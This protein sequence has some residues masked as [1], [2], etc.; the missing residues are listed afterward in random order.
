MK[1]YLKWHPINSIIFFIIVLFYTMYS[2]NLVITGISFLSSLICFLLIFRGEKRIKSLLFY[3]LIGI[4]IIVSNPLISQN[5]ET[6]LFNIG[7]VSISYEAIVFGIYSAMMLIS[8]LIWFNCYNKMITA[9]K[10]LYL[11]GKILPSTSITLTMGMRFIPEF[12]KRGKRIRQAQKNLGV[13]SSGLRGAVKNG[14][15]QISMLTSAALENSMEVSNSM[16]AR[17]Y[18]IKRRSN[19]GIYRFRRTDLIVLIFELLLFVV[20]FY[21]IF[22]SKT[23]L[24][25]YPKIGKISFEYSDIILYVA[26]LLLM[27]LPAINEVWEE[28]KWK[29]LKSKI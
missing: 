3:F 5:G 22:T 19:Y 21:G 6:I 16:R 7:K 28:L 2:T 29:F 26:T 9:D 18:G 25:Y 24:V 23:D 8:I 4:I 17:G 14:A 11:F 1:G 10:F 27:L 15:K 20:M 12:L 13:T